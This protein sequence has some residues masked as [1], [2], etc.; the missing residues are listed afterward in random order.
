MRTST[1]L[2]IGYST[3]VI[4]LG[5]ALPG[6]AGYVRGHITVN[7]NDVADGTF[8]ACR[9]SRAAPPYPSDRTQGGDYYCEPEAVAGAVSL[10]F[11]GMQSPVC[12]TPVPETGEIVCNVSVSDG[13]PGC[14]GPVSA[15]TALGAT[16]APALAGVIRR[17]RKHG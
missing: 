15:V 4:V 1:W 11:L 9:D 6:E 16:G 10:S 8:V 2:W 17:R 14:P 7:G 5:G 12:P 13:P 3:I